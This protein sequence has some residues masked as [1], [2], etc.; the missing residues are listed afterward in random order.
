MKRFFLWFC[1]FFIIF[2]YNSTIATACSKE[3]AVGKISE[4]E[5]D[6]SDGRAYIVRVEAT[7]ESATV[8]VY[9]L[10]C[11]KDKIEITDDTK[12]IV[13]LARG[14]ILT[15]TRYSNCEMPSNKNKIKPTLFEKFF[16]RLRDNRSSS[17]PIPIFNV[18]RSIRG[19]SIENDPLLPSGI[20]YLPHD[21][22]KTALLWRNGP[23]EVT[24]I[25]TDKETKFH[26]GNK[27]YLTVE[28]PQER[29]DLVIS[30]SGIS[31]HIQYVSTLPVP[32]GLYNFDPES[33]P[34][35]LIRALWIL[36]NGADEW[37]LFALSELENLSNSGFFAAEEFW[38][39]AL[40]GE[41]AVALSGD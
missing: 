35:R 17:R 29:S 3:Q 37:R 14:E 27:A 19:I 8:Q 34:D 31:W 21:H 6:K 4:I 40:T 13:S 5:W 7:N 2:F 22:K 18:V 24:L 36:K 41:L 28:L 20:Q 38:H 33:L 11:E 15:C 23:A 26:S 1:V 12:V 30:L 9:K 10:L 16:P 32:E 25:T 39:M